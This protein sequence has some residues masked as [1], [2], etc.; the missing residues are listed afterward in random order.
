[1]EGANILTECKQFCDL[2]NERTEY[3]SLQETSRLKITFLQENPELA[4]IYN[5]LVNA[6]LM[7][8]GE[9]WAV[10]DKYR[11]AEKRL[12]QKIA[13]EPGLPNRF[14]EF[15]QQGLQR[16]VL[17][18]FADVKAI[19]RLY[20]EV[21]ERSR[22][23]EG[24][25]P[26]NTVSRDFLAFMEEQQAGQTEL[27]GG[28]ADIRIDEGYRKFTPR[29]R[30]SQKV[31][32]MFGEAYTPRFGPTREGYGTYRSRAEAEVSLT[33]DFDPLQ[34]IVDEDDERRV[35][36][37]AHINRHARRMVCSLAGEGSLSAARDLVKSDAWFPPKGES[38][39]KPGP[40]AVAKLQGRVDTDG[41]KDC[42]AKLL[43]SISSLKT[44]KSLQNYVIR[45]ENAEATFDVV[46]GQA[47]KAYIALEEA[48]QSTRNPQPKS[49]Y[50]ESHTFLKLFYK[51]LP[52]VNR[53]R[54]DCL[55]R[56][57]S[58][59]HRFTSSITVLTMC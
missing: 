42:A 26:A 43:A 36:R 9:F 56:V 59:M 49:H 23:K 6:Q 41:T 7:E 14:L 47:G 8:E 17:L 4:Y 1:M 10:A 40:P 2:I 52:L 46:N 11:E 39:K 22:A 38:G 51:Q 35:E 18:S 12:F 53:S 32:Q 58:S 27:V 5:L 57:A 54:K 3:F 25:L 19:L 28:H 34:D 45:G 21:A 30:V 44:A 24:P 15:A 55:D 37:V 29:V 16:R 48:A 20:P 31:R 50:R 33:E 13:L